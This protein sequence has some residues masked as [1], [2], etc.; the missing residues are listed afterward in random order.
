MRFLRNRPPPGRG[1]GSA[2]F[3]S[4]GSQ[5]STAFLC[6]GVRPPPYRSN[7]AMPRSAT[8]SGSE[9]ITTFWISPMTTW[10]AIGSE[11]SASSSIAVPFPSTPFP[12][13]PNE[14]IDSP[15]PR[16]RTTATG[17]E[18]SRTRARARSRSIGPGA[19]PSRFSVRLTVRLG[20][21][22]RAS[23]RRIEAADPSSSASAIVTFGIAFPP[24]L[25]KTEAKIEKK[26]TGRTNDI[27]CATRSRV[28]LIQAILRMVVIIR[29]DP[30]R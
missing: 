6:S 20:S 17:T 24:W 23:A 1:A 29:A 12:A 15:R 4:C 16:G 26:T 7:M 9:V 8:R 10:G 21:R 28:K 18:P 3:F 27:S 14:P 5:P 22:D 19:P 2:L 11:G 13:C 30:F 25:P